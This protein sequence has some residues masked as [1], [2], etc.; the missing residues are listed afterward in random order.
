MATRPNA[1][2]AWATANPDGIV[3][4]SAADQQ[5][6]WLP[7][8][9][10]SA[11]YFNWLQSTTSDWLEYLDE[12][13]SGTVLTTTLDH[14]TR[15]IGGGAWSYNATSGALAWSADAYLAIPTAA[16]VSN[17]IPA[18]SAVVPAGSMAYVTANVP[19]TTMVTTASGSA[20]L[21]NVVYADNIAIG[22]AVFGPGIP[23][24]ATVQTVNADAG[25]VNISAPATQSA[26]GVSVT[27]SSSGTLAVQVATTQ[28]LVP[29]PNTVVVARATQNTC[30]VGVGTGQM[31]V[32]DKESKHLLEQGYGAILRMPAGEALPANAPVYLAG[33]TDG[34]TTGNLYRCDASAANGATRA[35][36]LGFVVSDTAQGTEAKLVSTGVVNGFVGLTPATVYYLNPQVV[37]GLT[38]TRPTFAGFYSMPVGYALSAT[39]MRVNPAATANL[40][41]LSDNFSVAGLLS[42]NTV[43]S[44][45]G[46]KS[47]VDMQGAAMGG[48]LPPGSTWSS[49]TYRSVYA[50]AGNT[51]VMSPYKNR[52][53]TGSLMGLSVYF[54]TAGPAAL[55][56][57]TIL[58]DGAELVTQTA[59]G[60]GEQVIASAF[61]KGDYPITIGSTL[62]AI[63]SVKNT[64][65]NAGDNMTGIRADVG[66]WLETSS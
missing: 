37:G 2:P 4:P 7:D 58:K 39:S 34:R 27:F 9:P 47:F 24:N 64:S 29:G 14:S 65:A 3:R 61:V 51:T 19:F 40:V 50:A 62:S 56:T 11:Q 25:T 46:F 48:S 60:L 17:T 55:C 54:N 15:L 52:P 12:Q 66:I 16:D 13:N 18:G 45:Q 31:K 59:S 35:Q 22:N 6:G 10:P 32:S 26:S 1:F 20:Q 33:P 43:R 63:V 8:Q 41:A 44:N 36:F 21:T 49:V 53:R 30:I 38:A 42:A 28:S 23:A 57:V 5:V